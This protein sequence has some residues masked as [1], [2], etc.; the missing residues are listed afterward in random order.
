[1]QENSFSMKEIED[2]GY[3]DF[4]SYLGVPYF[5]VGGLTSTERLAELCQINKDSKVLMVGCGTGFSAC[6][7]AQCFGCSVVGV[8]I[9]E[10]SIRKAKE[11]AEALG[12]G[13]G[14]EFR[15]G[16]AYDLPFEPDT[17]D[18]VITEFVSQFLDKNRAFREF[19]RVLKPGGMVGVNEM[20]RDADLPPSVAEEIMEAER[21]FAEITQ[22]PFSLPSPE[23]WKQWLEKAGLS[24]VQVY[25]NKISVSLKEFKLVIRTMG[26]FGEFTRLF[27]SLMIGMT[28]YSISSKKIRNRFRQLIKGKR[29]LMRKKA[30]SE[31]VGYVLAVGRKV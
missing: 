12:L 28:R 10:V 21:I 22:L 31:H 18:V 14:V 19:V 30:T 5:H 11:R 27:I 8:D 16:D 17:F 2:L 26:G 24:D 20:Y 29:I 25:K 23:E 6:F 3:Y 9:A 1:M 13:E 7:V 15:M 4:M